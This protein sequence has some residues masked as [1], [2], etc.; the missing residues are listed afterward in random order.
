[1]ANATDL[2][3]KFTS[4]IDGTVSMTKLGTLLAGIAGAL[5]AADMPTA[6][7]LYLQVALIIG[8]VLA[9]NGARDAVGKINSTPTVK[10][11]DVKE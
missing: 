2:V 3:K 5:L 1:M 11:P 7:D 6:W 10:D 8:G 4:N 9:A